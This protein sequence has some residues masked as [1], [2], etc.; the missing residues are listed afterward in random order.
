MTE[1]AAARPCAPSA[2]PCAPAR[3]AAV[4]ND[5]HDGGD[6]GGGRDGL[7]ADG[8]ERAIRRAA[9]PRPAPTTPGPGAG[10]AAA[11]D[12]SRAAPAAP[13]APPVVA[14]DPALAA[15]LGRLAALDPRLGAPP[16]TP[17]AAPPAGAENAAPPS[18]APPAPACEDAPRDAGLAPGADAARP[19]AAARPEAPTVGL[20]ALA[21]ARHLPPARIEAAPT[22]L[23]E[24]A[25]AARPALLEAPASPPPTAA[26]RL[27]LTPAGL[28]EIE[29]T[30]RLR[31]G[32]LEAVLAADRPDTAA[33]VESRRG[34]LNDALRRAGY[35]VDP[36]A[37]A[38][39]LRPVEPSAATAPADPRGD[40]DR[41]APRQDGRGR[42]SPAGRDAERHGR[43]ERGADGWR[44][45]PP[46]RRARPDFALGPLR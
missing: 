31:G 41:D 38:A 34:E 33:L 45:D 14:G 3:L 39:R 44:E 40:G 2:R 15:L 7:R 23:G 42:E 18:A 43:R 17:S 22:M 12:P 1:A 8:F 13:T 30:L 28:G 24:A 26:L 37:V 10:E 20:E 16:A 5:G 29:V 19:V 46:A 21:A 36:A 27:A 4:Q 32:R 6:D 11:P 35:E 25:A 9:A